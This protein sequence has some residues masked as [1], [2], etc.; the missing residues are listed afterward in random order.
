MSVVDC[1]PTVSKMNK[2][3]DTPDEK[4]VDSLMIF[5]NAA[6]CRFLTLSMEEGEK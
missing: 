2:F 6:F 3:A 1:E 5:D 4:E